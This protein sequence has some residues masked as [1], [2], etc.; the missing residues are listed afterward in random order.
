M[1]LDEIC[2][3]LPALAT[4]GAGSARPHTKDESDAYTLLAGEI[5]DLTAEERI[6]IKVISLRLCGLFGQAEAMV[7][8]REWMA[9]L[10]PEHR[11]YREALEAEGTLITKE[12]QEGHDRESCTRLSCY[13]CCNTCNFDAHRCHGCGDAQYHNGH[14]THDWH[15][16]EECME[17]GAE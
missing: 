10:T 9:G 8:Q 16:D 12:E 2:A 4:A 14:S 17:G 1:T 5:A 15:T 3:A 6:R 7:K 11:A 13:L